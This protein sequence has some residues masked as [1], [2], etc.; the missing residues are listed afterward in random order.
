MSHLQTLHAALTE[1]RLL[2]VIAG[3]ENFDTAAV[4]AI[5]KAAAAGGAQAIDIAADAG[6]IQAVKAAA[7]NLVV[8]VSATE[9]SKLIAAAA[10][11]ADVLELGNFDAMYRRGEQPTKAQI[12]AWTREVKAGAPNLPL[13]VTVCG[14][15]SVS[16]QKE[17]AVE[18][19]ALKVDLLQTEGQVGPETADTFA[20]LSGAVSALGNTAEIRKVVSLPLLL[21]GGFNQVSAPFAVAAGADALGVGKA[22]SRLADEAAMTAEV[23][24]IVEALNSVHNA[25]KGLT[26]V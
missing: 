6:L 5:A 19:E 7:P 24:A 10:A 23:K 26:R 20:A 22:V 25:G 14:R 15:L 18:L 3:I 2:K 16:E 4:V 13:C 9:P 21:A 1:R 17:L 8:F 12:L 11:G